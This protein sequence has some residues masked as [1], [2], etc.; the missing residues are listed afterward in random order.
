MEAFRHFL[1]PTLSIALVWFLASSVGG[2]EPSAVQRGAYI[3][4]AAGGCSCHTDTKNNGAF[5]AGGRPIKTPFGSIYSTNI[6]PEP[7][8]GIG[9]WS[10]ADF[11]RAMTEG[12]SPNGGHYFP[13]FPYTAFTRMTR[14][15]LLDLKTYLFSVA[16]VEQ[17][18][19][20][21]ALRPPFG[22]RVG[23]IGWKWLYFR[24]GTF[25][26]DP[27]QAPAWNRGA[28]LATA[29]GHCEECHTPR[30]LLGGLQPAMAYAGSVDGPEGELAPNITPDAAT[31]IGEW[32]IPDI[33]WFLQTG[34]KPDGDDTQGLMSELI[35]N[36]YKHLTEADLQAI[37]VYLRAQKPIHNKVQA[38]EK[39]KEE[40]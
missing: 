31:G 9:T 19:K 32:S 7:K 38:K 18:N 4:R 16:P 21:P 34:L 25:Q 23:L 6:T 33:V 24:P 3:F 27:A 37:A 12:V 35:E 26:P 30:N 5:L 11:I 2:Q 10:D 8:T 40:K 28:Y 36:G 15:D 14:Q 20:P 29:L 13:V 1:L 39:A 22:W 17:A